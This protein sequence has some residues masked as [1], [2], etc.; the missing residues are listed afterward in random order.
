MPVSH[1]PPQIQKRIQPRTWNLDGTRSQL[2]TALVSSWD[3]IYAS[4]LITTNNNYLNGL[5]SGVLIGERLGFFIEKDGPDDP[6]EDPEIIDTYFDFELTG[7]TN[8]GQSAGTYTFTKSSLNIVSPGAPTAITGKSNSFTPIAGGRDF[9]T[10]FL[11]N[12]PPI[13]KFGP[14]RHLVY[15]R[16]PQI[17]N[18]RVETEVFELRCLAI[19]GLKPSRKYFEPDGFDNEITISGDITVYPNQNTNSIAGWT[20]TDDIHWRI[21]IKN[22]AIPQNQWVVIEDTIPVSELSSPNNDGVVASFETLWDGRLENGDF[23]FVTVE[24]EARAIVQVATN[25]NTITPPAKTS[26]LCNSCYDRLLNARGE[27]SESIS[28]HDSPTGDLVTSL[29]HSSSHAGNDPS[30]MGYGWFSTENIKVLDLEEDDTDLVYCDEHGMCK[31]WLLDGSNYEPVLPDNRMA[32]SVNSSSSSAYY[33]VRWRDGSRREFDDDGN[34][35]KSVDR[36]GSETVYDRQ[37]SYLAI[38]DGKGRTVY[39]HYDSGEVQPRIINDNINSSLGRRYVLDYYM[40]GTEQKQLRSITD[41]EGN[42]T[43][44]LYDTAGRV[45]ERTEIRPEEGD[46]TLSYTYDS[47][48]GARLASMKV[49]STKDSSVLEL[50]EV[51][52]SY[53]VPLTYQSESFVTTKIV[54]TD[55][56]DSNNPPRELYRAYDHLSRIVAELELLEYDQQDD[57]VFIVTRYEHN[58]P[59]ETGNPK[60]PWLVTKVTAHN[61][62][63][64]E[65]KYTPRGNLR[66]MIDAQSNE[67][68]LTYV[69]DDDQHPAYATFPDL[70]TEVRRPA[71][72]RVGA[73]TT[74]YS[75]PRLGYN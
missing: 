51:E 37:T 7:D 34:L 1:F 52:Y 66:E 60:D 43:E 35:R 20:P 75:A 9:S 72:D 69:E 55:L 67:T 53:N 71:P 28:L 74:M 19:T 59:E 36:N 68:L 73:P 39:N 16:G 65:Y 64:T 42:T 29:N 5:G 21:T 41:P 11:V 40:D 22:D 58:D 23:C 50:Y 61:G 45:S 12:E 57:P 10:S 38:S 2:T 26:I 15:A 31:R 70:V 6:F 14:H 8:P 3:V 49:T 54:T 33:T 25:R 48:S 63:I 62:A 47:P 17:S 27:S 30:S 56:M 4:D 24:I 32:I 44:Y 46:R 13:E 18:D